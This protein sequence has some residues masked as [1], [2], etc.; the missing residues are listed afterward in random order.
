M[1]GTLSQKVFSLRTLLVLWIMVKS[2]GIIQIQHAT[3]RTPSLRSNG[4]LS[5]PSEY[6]REEYDTINIVPM[7]LKRAFLM[8]LVTSLSLTEATAADKWV[9]LMDNV[10]VRGTVTMVHDNDPN[11]TSFPA[12]SDV[13]DDE[14]SIHPTNGDCDFFDLIPDRGYEHLT[15][16][17]PGSLGV[18]HCETYTDGITSDP[19]LINRLAPFPKGKPPA[20][21]AGGGPPTKFQVL[22]LATGNTRN[23]RVGDHVRLV[24]RWVIDLSHPGSRKKIGNTDVGDVFVEFHPFFWQDIRLLDTWKPQINTEVISLAAPTFD[25][26][27]WDNHSLFISSDASDFHNTMAAEVD[28]NAPPL[29]GTFKGSPYIVAYDEVVIQNGCNLPKDQIRTVSV[30]DTG[31]HVSA[32]VTAPSTQNISVV[33]V[34][35]ANI[36][37][38]ANNISVFQA[39]YAVHWAQRLE[40]VSPDAGPLQPIK[41]D[42]P[43]NV[44]ASFD[45]YYFNRG[46][47]VLHVRS[48]KI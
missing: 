42:C 16:S 19:T 8:V 41:I 36:D 40:P 39:Q 15:G 26:V 6:L 24:G 4:K 47:D 9:W 34:P 17:L 20:D 31:I 46:P 28:I 5:K 10:E 2:I 43:L 14:L 35:V 44:G 25:H 18:I 11:G 21:V 30:T 32:H 38:P 23:L 3:Y 27:G 48:V 33:N 45:A 12:G 22:D 1:V 37:N 7:L 13:L 29:P